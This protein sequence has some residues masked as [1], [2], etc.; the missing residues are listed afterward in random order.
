MATSLVRSDDT[1][2][3]KKAFEHCNDVFWLDRDLLGLSARLRGRSFLPS[4]A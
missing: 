1:L 3:M 4:V 2:E